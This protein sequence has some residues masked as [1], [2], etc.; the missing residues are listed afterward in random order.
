MA[1]RD[2]TPGR[3]AAVAAG[4]MILFLVLYWLGHHPW[5][6]E[7][8]SGITLAY[9]LLVLVIPCAL[10]VLG[11]IWFRGWRYRKRQRSG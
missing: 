9:G 2:W 3:L 6:R 10:L 7:A 1:I 4:G 8:P 11:F 5:W